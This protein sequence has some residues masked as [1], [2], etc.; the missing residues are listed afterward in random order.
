MTEKKRRFHIIIV[1]TTQHREGFGDASI[2]RINGHRQYRLNAYELT[3]ARLARVQRLQAAL[4]KDATGEI[5]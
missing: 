4:A 1:E 5:E 2:A 3:P